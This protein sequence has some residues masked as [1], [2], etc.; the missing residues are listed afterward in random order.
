[1]KMSRFT[2][3]ILEYVRIIVILKYFSMLRYACVNCVSRLP[4]RG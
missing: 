2:I 1:M 4:W 3:T